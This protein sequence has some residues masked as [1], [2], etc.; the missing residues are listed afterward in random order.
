MQNSVRHNLSLNPAFRK[1]QNSIKWQGKK[2]FYWE[3][4]PERRASVEREVER[5]LRQ[6][7]KIRNL[8]TSDGSEKSS[9]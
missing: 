3:V 5:F 8:N 4:T 1:V 6:E 7:G 2:G 9:V